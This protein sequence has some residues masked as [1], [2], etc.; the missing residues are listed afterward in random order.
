M[1]QAR[2]RLWTLRILL[3]LGALTALRGAWEIV[4]A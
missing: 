2:F 4:S 3:A 1:D